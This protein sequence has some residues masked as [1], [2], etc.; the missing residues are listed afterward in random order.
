MAKSFL[1]TKGA[2]KQLPKVATNAALRIGGALGA[3]Y[4]SNKLLG[5]AKFD[6]KYHGLAILGL[7]LAAE[8]FV[9]DE[10]INALAQ[11][12]TVAGGQMVMANNLLPDSK[13]DF[14]LAGT[15]DLEIAAESAAVDALSGWQDQYGVSHPIAGEDDEEYDLP[16]LGEPDEFEELGDVEEELEGLEDEPVELF[17]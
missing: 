16:L 12:V 5:T 11:G 10:K 14:G 17:A 1:K 4:L 2:M 8:I 3:G 15:E 9:E 13:G 7:G 6:K